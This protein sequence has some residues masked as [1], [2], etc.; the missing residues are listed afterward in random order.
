MRDRA[1][2]LMI[3]FKMSQEQEHK[4][5]LLQGKEANELAKHQRQAEIRSEQN[6][7]ANLHREWQTE[8]IMIQMCRTIGDTRDKSINNSKKLLLTRSDISPEKFRC[9]PTETHELVVLQRIIKQSRD[10]P[11]LSFFVPNSIEEYRNRI[12]RKFMVSTDIEQLRYQLPESEQPG[13]MDMIGDMLVAVSTEPNE[14][15]EL[16]E[17]DYQEKREMLVAEISSAIARIGSSARLAGGVE[18]GAF[19]D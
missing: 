3:E 1:D 4:L 19:R 7:Q 17:G 16:L 6:F 13:V 15:Q 14:L 9:I 2:L 12:L 11:S 5:T 8:H 10:D 18:A